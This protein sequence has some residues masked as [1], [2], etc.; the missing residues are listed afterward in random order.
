MSLITGATERLFAISTI[1][2]LTLATTAT[3]QMVG[4]AEGSAPPAGGGMMGDGWGWGMGHG[5]YGMGGYGGI[6]LLVL[7]LVVI[8]IAVLA[9]RRRLP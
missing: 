4:Q 2:L 9:L 5:S 8:A 3:A 7:V 6:G 1:A